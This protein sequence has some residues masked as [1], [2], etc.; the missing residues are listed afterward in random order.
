M[1]NVIKHREFDMNK[2]LFVAFESSYLLILPT[3][4]S[5]SFEDRAYISDYYSDVE[6]YR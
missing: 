6:E 1:R 4:Y 2:I 3:V 5:I